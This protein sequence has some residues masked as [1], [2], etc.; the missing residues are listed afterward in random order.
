MPASARC[1]LQCFPRIPGFSIGG[2]C[3][4]GSGA[5]ALPHYNQADANAL[6]HSGIIALRVVYVETSRRIVPVH[7]NDSALALLVVVGVPGI[8]VPFEISIRSGIYAHFQLIDLIIRI[9]DDRPEWHDR[10]GANVQGDTVQRSRSLNGLATR[11][12][13]SSPKIVPTESLRQVNR[14]ARGTRLGDWSNQERGTEHELIAPVA[15]SAI[16]GPVHRQ[17]ALHRVIIVRYAPR[18]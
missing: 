7:V 3:D 16:R 1:N 15:H 18:E 6:G 5:V 17:S 13:C 2:R 12:P 8:G 14:A 10:A 11:H 4:L 9:V